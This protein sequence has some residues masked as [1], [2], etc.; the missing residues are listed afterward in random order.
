MERDQELIY[1]AKNTESYL[2]V[3]SKSLD[4]RL[5]QTELSQQEL[6]EIKREKGLKTLRNKGLSLFG[7]IGEAI[8][9]IINWNEEVNQ[10][11]NEAKKAHLIE[12]YLNKI[13]D[14]DQAILML[15]EF[16]T[17]P[18]GN[19]LFNK[20]IR[21]IEDFPPDEELMVHLSSVLKFVII[22]SDFEELFDQHKYA[23][24]QIE[25]L[26]PQSLSIIADYEKWPP[27]T[28]QSVT[29]IGAKI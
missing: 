1:I 7:N 28:L 20:I 11:I 8:S 2:H 25:R 27:I 18:Q 16:I 19:T 14:Q 4:Q 24:A 15:K 3:K 21:I 6:D 26:T 23:L 5:Q 29:S 22:N 13:D 10:E 12:Q 17:N 9:T